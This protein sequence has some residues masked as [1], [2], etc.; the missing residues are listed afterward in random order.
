[1]P[2]VVT[3]GE[4]MLRLSPPGYERF[5]QSPVLGATFGGGEA[6]VAVS[7]ALFG[8]DSYYV[9]RLPKHDIGEAAVRALRAEG[10]RTDFIIRGGD[11]VGVYFVEAGASQRASNV[12][13]DRA[14]S[15][16]S[17]L[18]PGTV[19]WAKVFQGADW[20]HVTGITPAL[21][22]KAAA[23]TR[24]SIE[25]AK[26]AGAK[27]SVDLNFRKKLWTEAQAQKVMRPLMGHVDVVI[28]NEEDM[29]SVLGLEVPNTDVTSGHL[30]L[31]G[32]KSVAQRLTKELGSAA[33]R[34]HAARKRVGQRQRVERGALGRQGRPVHPKPALRCAGGRSRRRRR[35][36][37]RRPDLR[38]AHRPRSG[39]VAAVCR[40]VQRAQADDSRRLQPVV[41]RRSRSPREGRRVGPR[42]AVRFHESM[43]IQAITTES[44]IVRN[45]ASAKGRTTAVEPGT[46]G[47]ATSSLRPHH[48]ERGRRAAPLRHEG[49]R[50]EPHRPEGIGA[51]QN[52]RQVVHTSADTTRFM[53]RA[54]RRSRSRRAPTAATSPRSRRP[55]SKRHPVQFVAF[56]DVQKDPGLHFAAGG[57]GCQRELN[58]LIGKN[59]EAG[60]LMAGVTFS[61]PGNWTSWPP[62]E[63][64]VLAEEA[65]LYIDMPAPAFGVQLVYTNKTDPEVATIVREG[66]VVLMPAGYHPNVAAPGGQIN[67]LW[68]MAANREDDDRLFGVVNVQPEFAAG[69]SGLDKGEEMNWD[70]IPAEQVAEG[71]ERQMV[72]GE[73]LMICRLTIQPRVVTAVHTHEHE[74]MTM[75]ERGRVLY[76]ID[77]VERVCSAGR[78][79]A[80]SAASF[81]M[82]RR[83]ST[84]KW[85]WSTSSRRGARISCA[86]ESA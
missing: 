31:E 36:F 16:I 86:E 68:M 15:A 33:G 62:H 75:V 67:F 37:C 38:V 27:V 17:E 61:A 40:R 24:E 1:M 26:K 45:T 51:G 70:T 34:D 46:N 52:G 13:Y 48:P 56:S 83:C 32:Y 58:I 23:C 19:D 2:K 53:C 65:Y 25:A 64:A 22:E 18:E 69:G 57:P 74:Q 81:R 79:P 41:G 29:Q 63:H 77:G 85:C 76:I 12:I 6:N 4:I 5:L 54:T 3:F 44:C 39:S 49:P 8:L 7:L 59:V 72:V 11:R 71:I 47:R 73:K 21:G 50:D 9:T 60:R 10:V 42:S 30:N 55:S 78:R 82:A 20:F 43:N 80:L 66:D 84:R 14:R 28:A 35:Q